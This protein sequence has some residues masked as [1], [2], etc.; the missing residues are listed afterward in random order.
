MEKMTYT[1][2]Y[3][4]EKNLRFKKI[5][6]V[7]GDGIME[8]SKVPTRFF[9]LKDNTRIEIPVVGTEFMFSPERYDIIKKN[10][11]DLKRQQEEAK[12][13]NN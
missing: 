8:D 1:V 2:S 12:K 5:K 13:Q 6:N 11:E 9:I 3:K 10:M 4:R 7:V